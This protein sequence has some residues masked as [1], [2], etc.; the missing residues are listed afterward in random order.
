MN[1]KGSNQLNTD[2]ISNEILYLI[3]EKKK[4]DDKKQFDTYYIL[5]FLFLH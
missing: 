5:T 3:R 2:K 4:Y 1:E